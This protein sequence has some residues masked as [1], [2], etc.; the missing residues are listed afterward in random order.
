MTLCQSCLKDG[1]MSAVQLFTYLRHRY[2]GLPA[3]FIRE[4]DIV[5]IPLSE[6]TAEASDD[7]RE[8][9]VCKG[10]NCSDVSAVWPEQLGADIVGTVG[11][12]D[13][14]VIA[15]ITGKYLQPGH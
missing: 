7:I 14:L 11:V 3:Y 13:F 9:A 1:P 15:Q 6:A 12:S 5:I 4:R 8:L 10:L 2:P